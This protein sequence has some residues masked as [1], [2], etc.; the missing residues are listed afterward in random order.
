[1]EKFGVC[2][3]NMELEFTVID[4][5]K[6]GMILFSEFCEWAITK[7]LQITDDNDSDYDDLEE[8]YK[9]KG[10]DARIKYKKYTGAYVYNE[11]T[12]DIY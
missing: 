6:G 3:E 4:R 2:P 9:L 1:M 8:D 11:K 12:Y 5:D 7:N 10:E